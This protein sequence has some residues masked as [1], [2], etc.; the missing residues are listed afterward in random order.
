MKMSSAVRGDRW[1]PAL[2]GS[3]HRQ[4]EGG[5]DQVNAY[6]Q[7]KW[8]LSS[9][10]PTHSGHTHSSCTLCAR[11]KFRFLRNPCPFDLDQSRYRRIGGSCLGHIWDHLGVWRHPRVSDLCSPCWCVRWRAGLTPKAFPK[12]KTPGSSSN[13]KLHSAPPCPFSAVISRSYSH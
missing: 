8:A 5:T 13:C 6:Y 4:T 1:G 12:V 3:Q 10:L 11:P 2:L 9:E 7:R